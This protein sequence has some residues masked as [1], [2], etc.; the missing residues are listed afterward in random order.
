MLGATEDT[1]LF[2]SK[3]QILSEGKA[4]NVKVF[5]PVPERGQDVAE[6]LPLFHVFRVD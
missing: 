5:P 1:Y 2:S 6:D 3:I 4:E